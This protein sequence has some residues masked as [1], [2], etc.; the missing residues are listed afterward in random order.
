V[1][2]RRDG[3]RRKAGRPTGRRGST[4]RAALTHR[5]T[6]GAVPPPPA[7]ACAAVLWC[8]VHACVPAC[9]SATRTP[10]RPQ[11]AGSRM[12]SRRRGTPRATHRGCAG[13]RVEIDR[14]HSNTSIGAL[15]TASASLLVALRRSVDSRRF[16]SG[17]PAFVRLDER[18][19]HATT[20]HHTHRWNSCD[21]QIAILI[22]SPPFLS[23]GV[24]TQPP[25]R[26]RLTTGL[27][28]NSHLAP[29]S[30]Q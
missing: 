16:E 2:G 22:L 15:A 12:G 30:K 19:R 17:T 14:A 29:H 1:L 26:T 28:N 13:K 24:T 23:P 11:Q 21:A 18:R 27:S 7:P 5:H 9:C 3:P 20:V 4:A 8:V 6:H 25:R 10:T